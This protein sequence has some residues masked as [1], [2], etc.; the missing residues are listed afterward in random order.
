MVFFFFFFF[1]F[2]EGR[3]AWIFPEQPFITIS[4]NL[5]EAESRSGYSCSIPLNSKTQ[6]LFLIEKK[7]RKK[8]QPKDW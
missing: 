8:N 7:K 1:F 4:S 5:L 6:T 2:L 3:G